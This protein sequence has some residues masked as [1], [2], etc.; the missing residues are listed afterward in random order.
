MKEEFI[1]NH[2]MLINV[3]NSFD[4]DYWKHSTKYKNFSQLIVNLNVQY[5]HI[6]F[7]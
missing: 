2:Y 5:V 7:V 4:K 6:I 3:F 1:V